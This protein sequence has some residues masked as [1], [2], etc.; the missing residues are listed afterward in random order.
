MAEEPQIGIVFGVEGGAEVNG[1]S[2]KAIV[3]QLT[4]LANNL[5]RTEGGVIHLVAGLD[6]SKSVS[7]IKKQL[8]DL[9]SGIELKLPEIQSGS[10][11]KVVKQYKSIANQLN[12]SFAELTKEKDGVFGLK[13]AFLD[14]SVVQKFGAR[15]K[16]YLIAY[17]KY[18]QAVTTFKNEVGSFKSANYVDGEWNINENNIQQ[19]KDLLHT[20]EKIVTTRKQLLAENFNRKAQE[21]ANISSNKVLDSATQYIRKYQETLAKNAPA[22]FKELNKLIIDLNNGSY[23]GREG[24]ANQL[25]NRLKVDARQAG[26]EVDNLGQSI[27]RIFNEKIGYGVLAAAAL[28]ARQSVIQVYNNVVKIDTAMTELKKVTDET[29]ATYSKF[30][31]TASERAQKLGS[32]I[33]DVVSATSDFSRLGYDL[34]EASDLADTAI[35]YKNVGDG[36]SD[37]GEASSSIISTIKAFGISAEDAMNVVD[38]FNEVGNNYAL[39]S[40]NVGEMLLRSASSMAAANNSLDETIALESAAMEIVQDDA[41]VGTAFKNISM[42]IRAAKEEAEAAG[43]S[44]D[45]MANS[46]AELQGIIK[47]IA[48]VDILQADGQ[49]FKSTFKILQEISKVWDKLS[50]TDRSLL[51]EKLG[52]GTRNANVIAAL[53]QNFSKAE[54][55]LATSQDSAGS[56]LSENEKYL[57]SIEGRISKLKATIEELSQNLLSS[58]LVKTGVGILNWLAK[59]A[60]WLSNIKLGA[61]ELNALL[62][63]IVAL[64]GQVNNFSIF[65]QKGGEITIL[66]STKSQRE[67]NKDSGHNYTRWENFFSKND[68]LSKSELEALTK[69][70]ELLKNNVAYEEAFNQTMSG[71]SKV[72][73]K[74]AKD[75]STGATSIEYLTVKSKSAAIG[76]GLLKTALAAVGNILVGLAISAVISVISEAFSNIKSAKEKFQESAAEAKTLKDELQTI[77]EKLEETNKQIAELKKK[78]SLTLVEQNQL[79]MLEKTS[80]ELENQAQ[81]KDAALKDKT[82]QA[83]KD[84]RS[85]IDKENLVSDEEAISKDIEIENKIKEV[86]S[87]LEALR[88][89]RTDVVD[90]ELESDISGKEA[91]L[92]DYEGNRDKYQSKGNIYQ[93][94]ELVR[95]LQQ[96]MSFAK[97]DKDYSDAKEKF[98][99][100]RQ[101][102]YDEIFG[103]DGLQSQLQTLYDTGYKYGLDK[104]TDKYIDSIQ[105]VID[106]YQVFTGEYDKLWADLIS[107]DRFS[108]VKEE[109]DKLAKSGKLTGA[110]L[111]NAFKEGG[112]ESIREFVGYLSELGLIDWKK[113]LGEDAF[114][115]ADLNADGFLSTEE[116]VTVGAKNLAP[117]LQGVANQL[118]GVSDAAKKASDSVKK[119]S[120]DDMYKEVKDAIS[121]ITSA[122]KDMDESNY[123][124]AESVSALKAAGLDKYIVQT[125]DGYKL[126][127]WALDNYLAKQ[128]AVYQTA[129]NSAV[130]SAKKLVKNQKDYN[131]ELSKSPEKMLK[132]LN[133]LKAKNLT[134][135]MLADKDLQKSI[136]NINSQKSLSQGEKGRRI[137]SLE[138]WWYKK[139]YIPDSIIDN[140][141]NSISNQNQYKSIIATLKRDSKNKN[142]KSSSSADKNLEKYKLSLSNLETQYKTD[143]ISAET[144]YKK[145]NKLVKKYLSN[146]KKNRKKYKKEINEAKQEIYKG[147][148]QL[149]IDNYDSGAEKYKNQYERG[150][151]S[152]KTYYQKLAKLQKK[153]LANSKKNR[154]KYAKE[155]QESQKE[156][157]DGLKELYKQDLERQK[158]AIEKKIKEQE[159][160]KEAYEDQINAELDAL[161]K[162]KDKEE[163]DKTDADL[164]KQLLEIQTKIRYLKLD[165]SAAGQKALLE[166]QQE[167]KDILEKI[168]ENN[169]E[170]AYNQT[171]D[172]IEERK[173][174]YL[175]SID[176]K[177]DAYNE[178]IDEIETKISNIT[179]DIK[180]TRKIIEAWAKK[181]GIKVA[182]YFATGTSSA[183]GGLA[184]T[185]E[186]GAETIAQSTGQGTYLFLQPGSKVWNAE[187]TD[188]LYRFANSPE[189]ILR[190]LSKDKMFSGNYIENK[191]MSITIGDTIIQGNADQKTVAQ[192]KRSQ[193]DLA[194]TVLERLKKL[195]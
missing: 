128:G 163:Q 51:T 125:A 68:A 132:Y 44:T 28:Y 141:K 138:A 195:K 3:K 54:E 4:E 188:F 95:T 69:F 55:I 107:R 60:S 56:A 169:K 21:T 173:E 133:S 115:K 148:K 176:N 86:T 83:Q 6:I 155:I 140:L 57:D 65:N 36:I 14:D 144:Y 118:N 49:T 16:D 191:P 183:P 120:F 77:N 105:K 94:I 130:S 34:N 30:L 72:A 123:L 164:A 126:A 18:K 160:E 190:T 143:K 174:A 151:I 168:D 10:A 127:E 103:E 41:K 172:S 101:K 109:L 97:D 50:D 181:H 175:K 180:G 185:Q 117:A 156:I 78:G 79:D 135:R 124:S 15:S 161:E 85:A 74:A 47:N 22:Q 59:A 43:E 192:I 159:K 158:A 114:N 82:S 5:N 88:A 187:A 11:D 48:G 153:W 96:G 87:E 170:K 62:P 92:S 89:K 165:M 178:Q 116:L 35:V 111:A 53:M 27:K 80:A 42:H 1:A 186:R 121:A 70:N 32:T 150:V 182:G 145:Y 81:L 13:N 46:V 113:A 26:G 39:S 152:A 29:D 8:A 194:R 104:T 20:Y 193:E 98:E 67:Y 52:G 157:Y 179:D 91:E 45:G 139:N 146:T 17:D 71:T 24:T 119:I 31:D 184:L 100:E 102:L 63:S 167:E 171:K 76:V 2:G 33:S 189:S 12:K 23:S 37:V 177:I 106:T 129:V 137:A 108:E 134:E 166:A 66:G 142:S 58:D 110:T 25:L 7:Q 19:A 99:T 64:L 73:Q 149:R 136:K 38:R 112:N 75:I 40:K 131:D 90:W 61:F 84:F 93:Q 9:Q 122:Q 147:Q 154:K 162:K